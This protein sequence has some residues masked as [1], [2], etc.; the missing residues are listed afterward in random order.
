MLLIVFLRRDFG[1]HDKTKC[2]KGRRWLQAS[3]DFA[4]QRSDNVRGLCLRAHV[5][6]RNET[7]FSFF[8]FN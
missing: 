5:E 4:A 1:N 3:V 8:Y 2:Q 7:Q 6:Y